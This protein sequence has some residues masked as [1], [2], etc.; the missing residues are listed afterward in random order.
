MIHKF[1]NFLVLLSIIFCIQFVFNYNVHAYNNLNNSENANE[2]IVSEDIS[3]KDINNG[4]LVSRLNEDE[5]EDFCIFPIKSGVENNKSWKVHFNKPVR[6]SSLYDNVKIIDKSNSEEIKI[7][8][9]LENDRILIV[10]PL[11]N[12]D[13][14]KI[15]CLTISKFVRS[16]DDTIL[17]NSVKMD[18]QLDNII[19]D[20]PTA[21]VTIN[22]E[23]EF[24]FPSTVSALMSDGSNKDFKVTWDNCN[25]CTSFP[26]N[27]TFYGNVENYKNKVVLNLKI[28]PFV[29]VEKISNNKRVQS[30]EQTNLYNYLMNHNNRESVLKRAI[31]LHDGDPSNTCVYFASEALRRSGVNLPNS[32]CNTGKLNNETIKNYSLSYQLKSRGWCVSKDLSQ[33]LPGDICFTTC[34]SGGRPTH[35]YTFMKWVKKDDYSYAYICDNQG[36]EYNN[37]YHKRNIKIATSSKDAFNYFMYKPC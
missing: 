15:Y 10:S 21:E 6:E 1:K 2:G 12:Y 8:L 25:V 31:Q 17:N 32:V 5:E 20:I 18:F 22:Q 19:K 24:K 9:S 36:Y 7:K 13:Y 26:G 29:N 35:V 30:K 37:S 28:N 33:L 14:G 16:K 23:D 3:K 4:N 11:E 27:Y 34:D